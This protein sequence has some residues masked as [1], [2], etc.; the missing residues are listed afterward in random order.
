MC[1]GIPGQIIEVIDADARVA[2]A[3]FGGVRRR[4]N[5][6]CV[7]DQGA[8]AEDLLG[9]WVLVH[10]GFAMSVIDEREAAE[11]LA[12]LAEIGELQAEVE[13]MQ[14]APEA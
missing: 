1:L 14:A 11:T 7:L 12:L 10:V 13:A 9:A 4:V 5:L 8:R 3:D 2:F 6:M